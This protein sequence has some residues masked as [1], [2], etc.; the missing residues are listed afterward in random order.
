MGRSPRRHDRHASELVPRFLTPEADDR[1]ARLCRWGNPD[2][3]STQGKQA[4]LAKELELKGWD[5]PRH[6]AG[7]LFATV[8]HGDAEGAEGVRR[9]LADWLRSMALLPAGPSAEIDRYIGYWKPYATN[10]EELDQDQA[11]QDEVRNAART[12]L[13]AVVAKRSGWLVAA[14]EGLPEPRQK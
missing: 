6:L 13:E 4:R 2:P 10:H 5:Y 14:G 9:S 7:R 3:T 11:I 1:P 8:V 12:L